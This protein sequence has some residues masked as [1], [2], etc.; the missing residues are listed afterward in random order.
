M[1]QHRSLHLSTVVAAAM[2]SLLVGSDVLTG[3]EPSSVIAGRDWASVQLDA[4][5]LSRVEQAARKW[6]T[7]VAALQRGGG[8]R[9]KYKGPWSQA[10]RKTVIQ[11]DQGLTIVD[12]RKPYSTAFT[13]M[14][15]VYAWETFG[16]Q[17]CLDVA[18]RTAKLY[19]RAQDK[20]GWWMHTILVNETGQPV[21]PEEKRLSW[22]R[23]TA[24]IQD[25]VQTGVMTLMVYLNRITGDKRYLEAARRGADL[26]VRA[27]NPNGS[28]SHHWNA[29]DLRGDSDTGSPHGGEI[30]DGATTQSMTTLLM[31]FHITGDR[32]YLASVRRG[33]EW[34]LAAQ[35]P[36]PTWGWASQY[37]RNNQPIWARSFEPPAVDDGSGNTY[38]LRGMEFMYQLTGKTRYLDAGIRCVDGL[39]QAVARDP[40]GILWNYYDPKTGR[41][42]MAARQD[43]KPV[44]RFLDTDA[45]ARKLAKTL[46]GWLGGPRSLKGVGSEPRRRSLEAAR[47]STPQCLVRRSAGFP[48]PSQQADRVRS[49][50]GRIESAIDFL[51]KRLA[52]PSGEWPVFGET[53]IYVLLGA[54][55]GARVAIGE[56]DPK[57]MATRINDSAHAESHAWPIANRFDTPLKPINRP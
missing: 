52:T 21:V 4:G 49:D 2:A 48:Q 57:S 27:Q 43:G 47:R 6:L 34:L 3:A 18:L 11:T 16:D 14:Q 38:A 55:R 25:H 23:S 8:W 40:E 39:K 35:L 42:V 30:N 13:A 44:M 12:N 10:A 19:L 20:Q 22:R 54:I 33:G 50:A 45:E 32:R 9:L 1:D 41:P 17:A 53:Q 28:W 37:D 31:M 7:T 56:I 26:L 15:F 5:Q 46:S 24:M 51:A 29:V 36:A